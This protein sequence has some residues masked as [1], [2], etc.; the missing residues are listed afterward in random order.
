MDHESS[1]T[2][3]S[4]RIDRMLLTEM[5]VRALKECI[6]SA[7]RS[8]VYGDASLS[9]SACVSSVISQWCQ[10]CAMSVCT[11]LNVLYANT[12]PGNVVGREV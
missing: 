8:L 3:S 1:A 5:A 6:Y 12:K 9:L 10:V 4:G 2:V 7:T 11:A